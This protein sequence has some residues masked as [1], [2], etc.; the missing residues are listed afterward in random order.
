MTQ[1][2]K[3]KKRKKITDR[4]TDNAGTWIQTKNQKITGSD[5]LSNQMDI[6]VNRCFLIMVLEIVYNAGKQNGLKC[7]WIKPQIEPLRTHS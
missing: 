1:S 4:Y 5:T 7:Y 3:K 2:L 6:Y